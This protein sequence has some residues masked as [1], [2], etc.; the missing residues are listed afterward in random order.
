MDNKVKDEELKT[1]AGGDS[2]GPKYKV[3]QIVWL[4]S[5]GFSRSHF[6]IER[7]YQSYGWR[8]VGTRKGPKGN[9]EYNV[10]IPE[11]KISS[12]CDNQYYIENF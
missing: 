8:Y 9:K 2:E 7:I 6:L 5:S 11:D 12:V 3:G 4:T 10:D 1:V